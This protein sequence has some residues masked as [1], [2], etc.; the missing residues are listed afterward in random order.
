[1]DAETEYKVFVIVTAI[2]IMAF[3]VTDF[4]MNLGNDAS[5]S[6]T[7]NIVIKLSNERTLTSQEC[8]NE[9]GR[10]VSTVAGQR[11][12]GTETLVGNVKGYL[13]PTIC[14]KEEI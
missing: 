14:C 7:S 1:M 9:G 4:S 2:L 12:G 10:L 6:I 8:L 11:C 3:F 5:N 13:S